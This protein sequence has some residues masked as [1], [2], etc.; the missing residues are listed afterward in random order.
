VLIPAWRIAERSQLLL[1][2]GGPI[3]IREG[4]MSR[5]IALRRAAKA[6]RRKAIVAEKRKAE[7]LA[8]SLSERV[9]RAALS[10]IQHCVVTDS[11]FE[12]GTGMVVLARGATPD[13]LAM[14]AFLV[15]V[16]CVGIKDAVFRSIGGPDFE[17]YIDVV[18]PG[19]R[20]VPVEPS[21]ARRLLR[22]VAIWARSAGFTPPP[23]FA[24]TE[25]L[26][27]EVNPD[28]SDAAFVFGHDGRRLYMPGPSESPSEI[29]RRLE[30]LRARFGESGF[31]YI[32]PLDEVDLIG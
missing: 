17:R 31:D 29:R 30:Q 14:G 12:V 27:G 3:L 10:P 5:N 6:N 19:Q 24:A 9:R 28:D 4:R 8:A 22:D 25:R 32:A 23:E 7:M 18:L 15:D 20:L 1:N 13:Y 21:F 2:I 16:F 11:L 26:F